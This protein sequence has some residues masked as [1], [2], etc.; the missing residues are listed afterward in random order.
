[1]NDDSKPVPQRRRF[2]AALGLG[3]L[4][5]AALVTAPRRALAMKPGGGKAG[6]HYRESDHIKKYYQVNRY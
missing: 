5:T 3:G 6:A 2:L 4:T 1:M